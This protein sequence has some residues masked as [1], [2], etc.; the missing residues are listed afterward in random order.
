MIEK[1]QYGVV[2]VIEGWAHGG[3]LGLYIKDDYDDELE[4]NAVVILGSPFETDYIY[5]EH[6][7]LRPATLKEKLEYLQTH[8]TEIKQYSEIL[9]L[10]GIN[11]T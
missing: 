8:A 6:S 5:F 10:L 4:S 3:N 1:G 2:A 7:D 11:K 9:T